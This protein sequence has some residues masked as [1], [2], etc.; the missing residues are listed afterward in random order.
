MTHNNHLSLHGIDLL[1]LCTEYGTPLFVFD[2]D[3]MIGNFERFRRAFEVNYPKSI[4]CYSI[5][6]NNNVAICKIMREIGA[7]A[8]V[9]SEL[10]LYVAD[11]AGFSGDHIIF[12]GPF[13]SEGALRE[14]LEK[15]VLL[16]NVES[17]AEMERLDKISEEMGVNQAIGLRVNS[18]KPRN[19][20]SNINPKNLDDTVHC[21]PHCRFGFSLKD[22]YSAF[23]WST[24][25][26][27]LC[28]EGV[29]THPYHGAVEMLLPL[30]QEVHEKLGIEIKYLNVGG[31]FKPGTTKGVNYVDLVFDLIR[32]KFGLSSVLDEKEKSAP[33]IESIARRMAEMVK[34]SG[35]SPEP[36]IITEPGTFISG[37]SG[38]LLLRVDH[39]KIAGGYRW[40]IVDGGTNLVPIA[41]VFTR[42]G[43][44]VANKASAPPVEMVNIAGPNLYSDDVLALKKYLP[45]IEEGDLLAVFDCGAYTLS[46]STQFLYPRPA[47]VL[48]NSRE[49]N[50]VIRERE[51][52]EDVLYKDRF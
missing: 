36:I 4:V 33:S 19:F 27:N 34:R 35:V 41:N 29:M 50:R 45:K 8:E 7:Y 3:C 12:D 11:K 20:F 43:V 26:K 47:A 5:K 23:E 28:V 18:F 38:I 51:T 17:P 25:F 10:D 31:G 13:K 24:R 39:T 44:V 22:A 49:E 21:H 37:P 46:S 40:V 2:E 9:G 14:A 6:T 30:I 32:E 15:E 1:D 52:F 42:R 16:I 48:V